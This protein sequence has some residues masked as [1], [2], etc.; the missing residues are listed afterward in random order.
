MPGGEGDCVGGKVG[1]AQLGAVVGGEAVL[2][3]QHLFHPVGDGADL[4]VHRGCDIPHRI[5]QLIISPVHLIQALKE[6][7]T[8]HGNH[9]SRQTRRNPGP[10]AALFGGPPH[11]LLHLLPLALAE[12]L[13][14]GA[15]IAAQNLLQ[16]LQ[17][18]R[19]EVH[20]LGLR[21]LLHPQQPA[22][23]HL[24]EAAQGHQLVDVGQR[25]VAF[26]L[27]NRLPGHPQLVPQGLLGE[28]Q[29]FPPGGDLLSGGHGIISS[30]SA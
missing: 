3:L 22:H 14:L 1:G 15:L 5:S 25:Q 28:L 11:Q 27:V 13:R 4:A 18:L 23:G 7:H 24:K 26:P 6:R 2:G 12:L 20:T 30:L 21:L 8:A 10:P 9:Q 29:L 16:Q 19:G 17:L